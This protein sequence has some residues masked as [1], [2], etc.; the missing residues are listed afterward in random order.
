MIQRAIEQRGIR[1]A[2]ISHLPNVT[3][4]MKAPR[5]LYIRFPLGRTFGQ[6]G[7]VTTQKEILWEAIQFAVKGEPESIVELPYR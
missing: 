2:G 6:A 7:D 3:K 5:T 1:T 4:K